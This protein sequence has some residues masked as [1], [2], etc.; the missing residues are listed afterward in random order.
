MDSKYTFPQVAD[1]LDKNK[2]AILNDLLMYRD[3]DTKRQEQLFMNWL[4][5]AFFAGRS[6]S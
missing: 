3:V 5:V 2:V 1:F 4:T 6:I